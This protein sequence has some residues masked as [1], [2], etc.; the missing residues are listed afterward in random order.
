M[1]RLSLLACA[2]HGP[3]IQQKGL[4][5]AGSWVEQLVLMTLVLS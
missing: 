1:A 4:V 3:L 2:L 5:L